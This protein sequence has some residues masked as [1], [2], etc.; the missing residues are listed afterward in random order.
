MTIYKKIVLIL[1]SMVVT[2]LI[3]F[4]LIE[5]FIIFPSFESLEQRY[6]KQDIDRVEEMILDN[7]N[8]LDRQLHDLSS[9]DD[10]YNFIENVDNDYID[11]NLDPD[12][13]ANL[14]INFVYFLD[15][16]FQPVWAQTYHLDIDDTAQVKITI[17]S[18][19]MRQYDVLLEA[20]LVKLNALSSDEPQVIRGLFFQHD[21]AISFAMRPI[22]NHDEIG[23]SKGYIILGRTFNTVMVDKFGEKL[24]KK[25]KIDVIAKKPLSMTD[26]STNTYDIEELSEE[27]L[28]ISK[29]YLFDGNAV[30][31]ISTEFQRV[32]TQSGQNSLEYAL[33]SSLAIGGIMIILIAVLLKNS[34]FVLLS[35][36]TKQMQG[37]SKSKNYTLR[38]TINSVDEIGVLSSEFNNMLAVI[39]K[40]NNEL[41]DANNQINQKNHELERLSLT[42][43]L[44]K[45][46]NRLGLDLHLKTEWSALYRKKGTLVIIMIDIDYFKLFNDNYGHLEGDK[47][48]QKIANILSS[49]TGRPR[50][51]AARFGGE[52]FTLVLPET[53][54]QA[55][56]KIA[57]HIQ[58]D[59]AKSDI[60]HRGSEVSAFVT[61]S[62][63]IAGVIPSINMS[64]DSI[65]KNADKALYTAKK[66]GRNRIEVNKEL[67]N[68]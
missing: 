30:F 21:T 48:L 46:T 4:L 60:L 8:Q 1:T 50:D 63:G 6:A 24:K 7:I 42:D 58:N 5:R 19:N 59:I 44:T 38:A 47:C 28:K 29:S 51:M 56:I 31:K 14:H 10:T 2:L 54:I 26:F 9:R 15:R 32:I 20:Q 43:P 17:D 39:E 37:I 41:I 52:E 62:I 13:F 53:D 61:V 68:D 11:S 57:K 33:F 36:L 40:N 64:V 65:M 22:F 45:I 3:A 34:V 35:N 18:E 25:F 66:N 55:A 49:N 23:A 27:M 67:N 12:T 16:Q